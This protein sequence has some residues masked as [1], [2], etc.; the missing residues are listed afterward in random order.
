MKAPLLNAAC[1]SRNSF[2]RRNG[3]SLTTVL[4]LVLFSVAN[5][6][7]AQVAPKDLWGEKPAHC[8][9]WIQS[10]GQLLGTDGQQASSKL[11]HYQRGVFTDIYLNDKGVAS[12]AWS[13]NDLDS[14]TADTT[15]R[16]DLFPAG[17]KAQIPSIS[18]PSSPAIPT[19]TTGLCQLRWKM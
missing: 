7:M 14:A 12:F 6:G 1:G 19:T 3:T 15:Y 16:I 9:G 2:L 8:H 13:T 17:P 18:S 4:L 10:L 5:R 11:T